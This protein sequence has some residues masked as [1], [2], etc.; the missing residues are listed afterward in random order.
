[1]FNKSR[2]KFEV[3]SIEKSICFWNRNVKKSRT[4]FE[5]PTIEKRILFYNKI[6][7][8]SHAEFGAWSIEK[9]NGKKLRTAF[10]CTIEKTH[11]FSKSNFQQIACKKPPPTPET[12]TIE[13]TQALCFDNILKKSH[14][15]FEPCKKNTHTI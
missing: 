3:R 15:N 13:K 2:V 14:S 10:E 11:T 6:L 8:K 9:V 7:K 4:V 1:M 5:T 12:C